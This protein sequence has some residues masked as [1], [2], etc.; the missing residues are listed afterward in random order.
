LRCAEPKAPL[1]PS[2]A[3]VCDSL[4][5]LD[6]PAA[7]FAKN[8][9]RPSSEPQL[10]ASFP[11]RASSLPV[12]TQYLTIPGAAEHAVLLSRPDW[13]F[14]AEH[15]VNSAGVAIGN[16]K[17]FTIDDPASSPPGLIGMDLVRLGLERAGSASDAVD[18][19]G[20]LIETYGQG[21]TADLVTGEAYNSSFLICDPTEA[22]VVET[23]GRSWVA[24]AVHERTSISN[25]ISTNDAWERSSAEIDPGSDFDLFRDPSRDTANADRRLAATRGFLERDGAVTLTT[26]LA[27]LR[28]H[29]GTPGRVTDA[30]IP[31]RCA[32]AGHDG[33]MTVCMHLPGDKATTSSMVAEL[34]RDSETPLLGMASIGSPCVMP[35]LP[36]TLPRTGAS[37]L[38]PRSLGE[39]RLWHHGA[40][41]RG[42]A[43][44]DARFVTAVRSLI[45]P[46]ESELHGRLEELHSDPT[47]VATLIAR[48]DELMGVFLA[49]SLRLLRRQ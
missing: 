47:Q 8:S 1:R 7:I 33:V 4:C 41:L 5:A 2:V 44:S 45:D 28:D 26:P 13:L 23:S 49:D 30:P 14:G 6:G 39:A 10:V 20:S 35:F 24:A 12:S 11:A 38:F 27:I 37:A 29:G 3:G 18:V 40:L 25:R 34:P 42:A 15:G 31:P 17:I 32:T 16:E 9:D 46:I 48:A 36:F 19:I 22:W 21:G 43:E